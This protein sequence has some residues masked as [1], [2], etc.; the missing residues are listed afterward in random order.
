MKE[1]ITAQ[2]KIQVPDE[3][4]DI[5]YGRLDDYESGDIHNL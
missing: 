3:I 5:I 2:I 4:S 1:K